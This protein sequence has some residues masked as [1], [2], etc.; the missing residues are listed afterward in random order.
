MATIMVSTGSN[1]VRTFIT[2]EEITKQGLDSYFSKINL[3]NFIERGLEWKTAQLGH[4]WIELRIKNPIS[5]RNDNW[6]A[7]RN[8]RD[9]NLNSP[10]ERRISEENRLVDFREEGEMIEKISEKQSEVSVPSSNEHKEGNH[11]KGSVNERPG[12]KNMF[13]DES[14]SEE[15]EL[16]KDASDNRAEPEAFELVEDQKELENYINMGEAPEN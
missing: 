12:S 16:N 2:F 11:S 6:V 13:L 5:Q 14:V 4:F 8:E 7:N 9:S 15:N 3:E 1:N 10:F